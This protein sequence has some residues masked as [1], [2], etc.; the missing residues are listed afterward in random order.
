MTRQARPFILHTCVKFEI[1]RAFLRRPPQW[2][3]K[4]GVLIKIVE[5]DRL[6]VLLP[7]YSPLLLS[8][9]LDEKFEFPVRPK[10]FTTR[11][12]ATAFFIGMMNKSLRYGNYIQEN[13]LTLEKILA[14]RLVEALSYLGGKV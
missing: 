1:E 9:G 10:R 7:T 11:G 4:R 3:L 5:M 12:S 14:P 6:D 2:H 8:E 13:G